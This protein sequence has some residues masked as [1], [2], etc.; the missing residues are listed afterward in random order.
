MELALEVP[1]AEQVPVEEQVPVAEQ[2][3][4]PEAQVLEEARKCTRCS[5]EASGHKSFWKK[6][7]S[8]EN[9]CIIKI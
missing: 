2:V 5:I 1:V 3:P 9:S 4:D 6:L 7:V 8:F